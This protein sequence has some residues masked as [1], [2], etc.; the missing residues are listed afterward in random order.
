MHTNNWTT[1][2]ILHDKTARR[3]KERHKQTGL[4][5][6]EC[7]AKT[8]TESSLKSQLPWKCIVYCYLEFK[9]RYLKNLKL[10]S[11]RVKELFEP[12]V[13]RN[14]K[15]R[16][17]FALFITF[18][19]RNRSLS[20]ARWFYGKKRKIR[21]GNRYVTENQS[22]TNEIWFAEDNH[23]YMCHIRAKGFLDPNFD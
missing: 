14:K 22:K 4:Y 11:I 8:D 15:R 16:R 1:F 12:I 10:F 2:Y 17:V 21:K 19:L 18:F 13:L 5:R 9:L 6:E 7:K 20:N 23:S 3:E